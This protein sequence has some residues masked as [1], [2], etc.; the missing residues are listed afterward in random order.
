MLPSGVDATV[1]WSLPSLRSMFSASTFAYAM[2]LSIPSPW[3][4]DAVSTPVFE[5][6]SPVS[7][8]FS[9]LKPKPAS[10]VSSASMLSSVLRLRFGRPGPV[11]LPTEIVSSPAS[12][13]IVVGPATEST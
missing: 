6:V 3:Y 2:P 8:V 13:V 7:Y 4:V 1:K 5:P 12:V 11:V 9:V 10:R